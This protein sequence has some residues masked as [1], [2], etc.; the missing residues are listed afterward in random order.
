MFRRDVPRP[1]IKLEPLFSA[2]VQAGGTEIP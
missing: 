1:E 2:G